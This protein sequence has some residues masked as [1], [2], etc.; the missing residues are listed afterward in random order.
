M[1]WR[2]SIEAKVFYFSAKEG[3]PVLRLEERRSKFLGFIF[4]SIP[5]SSWLVDT[6]EAACLVK[7]D[8]AKS[9]CEGDK[10]CMVHGGANKAGRFLEVSI[11]VEGG[12]KGVLWIPE[13]RSGRGWRR[14]A[15]ELRLMVVPAVGKIGSEAV[16]ARSLSMPIG[17]ADSG[18]RFK[19]RSFAEVVQSKPSLEMKGRSPY[20][21]DCL[22]MSSQAEM[23]IG[24]EDLRLT[25]DC[26]SLEFPAM[27]AGSACSRKEK[28][29]IG[30]GV[31]LSLLGQIQR[32]LDR[33]CAGL[34]SK[35][36]RKRR[37]IHVLGLKNCTGG[38]GSGSNQ[39]WGPGQNSY[40]DHLL[41]PGRK[42]VPGSRVSLE[43]DYEVASSAVCTSG[44]P[45]VSE[46]Y[47]AGDGSTGED[48]EFQISPVNGLGVTAGSASDVLD[49]DEGSAGGGSAVGDGFAG[50]AVLPVPGS[51][52]ED[53]LASKSRL[54]SG[55]GLDF[56]SD[57]SVPDLD[58][59]FVPGLGPGS[60]PSPGSVGMAERPSSPAAQFKESRSLFSEPWLHGFIASG[61]RSHQIANLAA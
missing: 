35:P 5:C 7:E 50:E 26:S 6:V 11:Y 14:F 8:I 27:A 12:R 24:G 29:K 60:V 17:G 56:E 49:A 37:R 19:E 31:L 30:M 41:R 54:V 4:A 33:V 58:S 51:P 16:Q 34:A 48:L 40:M 2:F 53:I 39:K 44:I 47:V 42:Q 18:G 20:S 32:K 3:S 9:F 1:E 28:G 25:V 43:P 36:N 15:E 45:F 46:R 57:S 52:A 21:M 10:V 22:Q 23:G 59:G 55:S 13:G 38:W 61:L